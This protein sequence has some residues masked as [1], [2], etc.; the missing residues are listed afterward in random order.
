MLPE[1]LQHPSNTAL[2]QHVSNDASKGNFT[3]FLAILATLTWHQ[4]LHQL[5]ASECTVM[6]PD[7]CLQTFCSGADVSSDVSSEDAAG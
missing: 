4:L 5:L 1:A 7:E 6:S 2:F 3:K